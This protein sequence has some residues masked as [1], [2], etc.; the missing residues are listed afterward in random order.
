MAQPFNTPPDYVAALNFSSLRGARIGIPRN[1]IDAFLGPTTG[2]IMAAFDTAI[3]I[4]KAAGAIVVDNTNFSAFD[5]FLADNDKEIGNE[6][7]VL[8]SL[9]SPR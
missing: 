4:I 3:E 9:W 7:I 6:T 5:Q 8:V 2:P 1:G